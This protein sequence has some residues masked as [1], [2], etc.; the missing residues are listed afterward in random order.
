MSSF[1]D[2][3]NYGY[4]IIRELGHNR[5]GGRVTYLASEINT[6][7]SVVVKQFQF[8]RTGASWSDYEAYEREIQ[9]LQGLDHPSIPRYLDSFQTPAGFCMVQEYKDA[10]SLVAKNQWTPPQIK[11]IAIAVLDILKY[12]QRQIPPVIHRD[13]K[14][15]NILVDE[16]MNV[17]LVDFGFARLGGGEVA[18]S[19][20]IKGTLGFMPPEQMFNRQLTAASDLY[21]LGATLICL[22]TA[23]PS[24]AVGTLVEDTGRINF[25]SQ[26]SQLSSEFIDWLQK[27]VEPNVKERYSRAGEALEALISLDV[28]RPTKTAKVANRS[29]PTLVGLLTLGVFAWAAV[30]IPSL[31]SDGVVIAITTEPESLKNIDRIST[32]QGRV[33]FS[34]GFVDVNPGKNYESACQLFDGKG[35]LVAMGQATLHPPSNKPKAWC[36]YDFKPKIDQPGN[37]RF[38]FSLDGQKV[39]ERKFI[40]SSP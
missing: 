31:I 36:W 1:P 28:L 30:K 11:Q 33:Y 2:F 15:E 34:I 39:G 16:R 19:S 7:R 18:V 32:N 24:T 10:P 25:K 14:P 20:V 22:L 26:V 21:S 37:W 13:L 38:S 3:S 29:L 9:V 5:A 35:R 27:M 8:A 23:T 12:L 17:Y 6:Q 40:V 4:Q